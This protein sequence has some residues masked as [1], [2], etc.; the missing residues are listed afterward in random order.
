MLGSDGGD[1][2]DDIGDQD[3]HEIKK[4]MVMTMTMCYDDDHK[5][6]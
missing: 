2:C 5:D 3:D 4:M 6:R 1:A